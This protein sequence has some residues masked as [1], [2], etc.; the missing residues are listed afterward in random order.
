MSR[1]SVPSKFSDFIQSKS[2]ISEEE[3][4][5][6][7]KVKRDHFNFKDFFSIREHGRLIDGVIY[8]NEDH[9]IDPT[10][11]GSMLIA[12]DCRLKYGISIFVLD[13]EIDL[14]KLLSHFNS[15]EGDK[16]IGFC[17]IDSTGHAT[18]ILFIRKGGEANIIFS[19]TMGKKEIFNMVRNDNEFKDAKIYIEHN[20][21]GK[22]IKSGEDVR[23]ALETTRQPGFGYCGTDALAFLEIALSM[24]DFLSKLK[25]TSHDKKDE[26]FGLRPITFFLPEEILQLSQSSKFVKSS[27]AKDDAVLET[28][29]KRRTLEQ[30]IALHTKKARYSLDDE[31]AASD[32][33]KE[34]E[35]EEMAYLHRKA[36]K[37]LDKVK[38]FAIS[39]SDEE[40]EEVYR[41]I[42]GEDILS[43]PGVAA[44]SVAASSLA[45]KEGEIESGAGIA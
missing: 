22:I 42:S 5:G 1:S 12:E 41:R 2:K 36:Y 19:D 7:G 18:P 39:H 43:I 35:I 44:A 45:D 4:E 31:E 10:L 14:R 37:F 8:T 17:F 38:R 28:S 40:L 6:L 33:P 13:R 11:K 20:S 27:D 3:K 9:I 30:K 16:K 25:P 21:I 24:N 15:S 26:I 34:I 29:K 23:F 32:A